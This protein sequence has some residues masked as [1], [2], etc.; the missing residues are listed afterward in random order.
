MALYVL[1]TLSDRQLALP[2]EA[3]AEVV[4][5]PRLWSPPG[6]PAA[7]AGVMSVRGQP[8]AVARLE[9][10]LGLENGP[11]AGAFTPV[12]ILQGAS[13]WGVAVDGA[14][15]E[16]LEPGR[17]QPP[18]PD[19]VFNNCLA[20]VAE[21]PAG[22]VLILDASRLLMAREAAV[23]TGFLRRAAERLELWQT[24]AGGE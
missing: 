22:L 24:P 4:L 2:A 13:P 18:P 12:V 15:V 14:A 8:V 6:L 17:V 20:A 9:V 23:L 16:T 11:R 5:L 21:T 7:L 1:F 10:L 3:V 19:A